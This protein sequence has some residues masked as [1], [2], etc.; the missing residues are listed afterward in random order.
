MEK[1]TK[2]AL[3]CVAAMTALTFTACDGGDKNDDDKTAVGEFTLGAKT[4]NFTN[5]S[6]EDNIVEYFGLDYEGEGSNAGVIVLYLREKD[7]D[8]TDGAYFEIDMLLAEGEDHLL[9]GTYNFSTSYEDMTFTGISSFYENDETMLNATGG[10]IEVSI[11]GSGDN[12]I[13][14]IEIEMSLKTEDSGEP[15]GTVTGTW[16]G[17]LGWVE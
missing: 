5:T 6:I 15:A 9:E 13:Y 1:L 2:L 11:E 14:T 4:W 10:T 16:R 3:M 12:A 8:A 17:K 7:R